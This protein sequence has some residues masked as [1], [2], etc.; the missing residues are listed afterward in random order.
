MP[1]PAQ[2]DLDESRSAL[3]TWL[4]AKIPEAT[5]VTVSALSVPEGSGFS[6]ETL[7]AD[8]TWRTPHQEKSDSLVIRVKPTGYQIFLEADFELQYRL[9]A[10][11]DA[12]TDVPVP[13][14]LWFETDE[15][16]LGAPFFVMR[17]VPGRAAADRPPYNESGWLFDATPEERRRLW[18]RAVDALIAVHRVPTETVAFLAKPELGD[19]GFDQTLTYWQR[20]FEWAKR[21]LP[22]PV[23]DAA[24]EWLLANLPATRP[25]ALSWGDARV[26]NILFHEGAVTAVLDWEMLSLG[27]HEMDLGWWLFLDDYH[28]IDVP[29][30]PGL[31][32]R[33]ETIARWEAGTGETAGDLLWYEIFAGFRFVIVMMRLSQMFESWG[34]KVSTPDDSET[35]NQVTRLLA[36]K[37]P[38]TPA[39]PG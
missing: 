11:L 16:V 20:S 18:E 22:N 28:T 14:T 37:I 2:R 33:E 7:L 36:A 5:E 25:T 29:R 27:G 4:A 30:L 12:D 6:N 10:V 13:P 31:G 38:G 26:G 15:S 3:Q 35:N 17:R 32:D 21:G 23:G 34:V 1:I 19:T 39:F 8:I 9:L 24:L